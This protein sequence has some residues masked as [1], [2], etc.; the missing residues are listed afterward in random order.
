MNLIDSHCHIDV[1][2]F[3]ADRADVLARSR[4]AGVFGIVVP[5]VD[6]AGWDKLLAVCAANPGLYPTL[7]L[8]P[9]YIDCHHDE[10]V[11]RLQAQI[12]AHRPVAIGEIGLDYFV[13]ELDRTR[14]QVLFE[15]QLRIARDADLPV[16]LHI[17]KA[18]DQVLATLR[19]F[20]VRGGIAHAFNASAQQARQ[21]IELGFLLGFGGTMT[22]DRANRIRTLAR[23]VPIESIA[24]ETDAPDIPL[25]T[26]RGQRNSPEYLPEC[27]A[28]LAQLR[29]ADVDDVARQTT[30][31]V[32]RVLNL[33]SIG[34][35]K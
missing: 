7:G 33:E 17:R 31:N 10:H 6:A 27:L 16:I 9:V 23:D 30:Q 21:F 25:S 5:G 26:H 1:S 29:E 28:A 8:H 12:C 20:R 3:D 13:T 14:Q 34:T 11:D 4:A 35:A 15:A 19:R 32:C 18:H 24:L 2:E 22:Y